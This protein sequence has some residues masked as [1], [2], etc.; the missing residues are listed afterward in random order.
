MNSSCLNLFL[1]S[2]P[3]LVASSPSHTPIESESNTNSSISSN[4]EGSVIEE[5]LN[6]SSLGLAAINRK[7]AQEC[8]KVTEDIDGV[9]AK[10]HKSL[11]CV[12]G[13][14]LLYSKGEQKG[15]LPETISA[16]VNLVMN[17]NGAKKALHKRFLQGKRVPDWVL[18][19]FKL[20]AKLP[21]AA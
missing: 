13:N 5:T 8:R 2:A 10:Y 18:L 21:D 16:I 6:S 12:L 9:L 7:V 17:A 20:Q 4:S 15:K 3:L 11:A 14:S 1:P 19:Y